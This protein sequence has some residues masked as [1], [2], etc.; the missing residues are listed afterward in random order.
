MILRKLKN[1]FT[2]YR[3]YEQAILDALIENSPESSRGILKSQLDR[4]SKIQRHAGGREVNLYCMKGGAAFLD[5]SLRFPNSKPELLLAKAAIESPCLREALRAE[6]WMANGRI[7]S[8]MF[9]RS[10]NGIGKDFKVN[11][12]EIL[13]DPMKQFVEGEETIK[14]REKILEKINASLPEEYIT[15]IEIKHDHSINGWQL[16]DIPNIRKIAFPDKNYY[17]L[18]EKEGRGAIAV[19]ESNLSGELFYLDYED[20]GPEKIRVPLCDFIE[21]IK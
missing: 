12:F 21:A 13:S 8:L 3:S 16:Y 9:N 18:A 7:F 17:L 5:E 4:V 14:D 20:D 6:V 10:P 1:L 19:A 11:H 15:M 2:Q